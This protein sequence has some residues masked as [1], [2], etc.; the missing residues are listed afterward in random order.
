MFPTDTAAEHAVIK[1]AALAAGADDCVLCTHHADGGKGAAALG[2]A[3]AAACEKNAAAADFK[4][5]YPKEL[6][7]KVGS[8]HVRPV[9][10]PHPIRGCFES[11]F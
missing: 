3:V 8:L 6:S 9:H 10:A 4:L 7:I 1:E 11:R 2:E 5:L